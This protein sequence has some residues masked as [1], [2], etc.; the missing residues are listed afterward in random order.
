[1]KTTRVFPKTNP[2]KHAQTQNLHPVLTLKNHMMGAFVAFFLLILPPSVWADTYTFTGTGNWTDAARWSPSA[3]PANLSGKHQVVVSGNCAFPNNTVQTFSNGVFVLFDCAAQFTQE[4]GSFLVNDNCIVVN[5]GILTLKSGIFNTF[6]VDLRNLNTLNLQGTG[7]L[8]LD[9]LNATL[10]EGIFNWTGGTVSYGGN[11][12]LTID[13]GLT[14]PNNGTLRCANGSIKLNQP[15]VNQGTIAIFNSAT[16][17]INAKLTNNNQISVGNSTN[18]ARLV[19]NNTLENLGTIKTDGGGTLDC[20]GTLEQAGV[21]DNQ[22]IFKLHGGTIVA[23]TTA[24]LGGKSNFQLGHWVIEA[25]VHLIFEMQT[26]PNGFNHNSTFNVAENAI[27]TLNTPTSFESNGFAG[28]NKNNGTLNINSPLTVRNGANNG[29]MN[30]NESVQLVFNFTNDGILNVNKQLTL[31]AVLRGNGTVNVKPNAEFV[32]RSAFTINSGV[33][34]LQGNLVWNT[35]ETEIIFP[36]GT[37]NWLEG[38]KVDLT[39]ND[40]TAKTLFLENSVSFNPNCIFLLGRTP[41]KLRNGG[42]L[43]LNNTLSAPNLTVETGS[44]LTVNAPL[45]ITGNLNNAAATSEITISNTGNISIGTGA[46][47]TNTGILTNNGQISM[48]NQTL[49]NSGI[50]KGAGTI[51]SNFVN[52]AAGTVSVGNSAG[53]H[54]FNR[55]FTTTGKTIMEIGGSTVCTQHDKLS[56]TQTAELGGTLEVQFIN[57]FRPTVGQSFTL[58]TAD[59]VRGTFGTVT[60]PTGITGSVSYTDFDVKVNIATVLPVNLMEFSGQNTEGGNLLNWKTAEEQNSSHFDIERSNNGSFFT[61]IKDLKTKGS[62]SAYQFLDTNPNAG[63]NYYRLKINDLDGKNSFSKII[64]LENTRPSLAKIYPSLTSGI[65]TIE[66]AR[67]FEIVNVSG[68]VVLSK[69]QGS[70]NF[71]SF[72]NLSLSHLPNGI[73]VVK[74]MDTEGGVF[75]QKIVKQ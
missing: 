38:G 32:I 23:K 58:L 63:L 62:N 51:A 61:K 21:F 46:T 25:G 74:G 8:S 68:Q 52:A 73:Y 42:N 3:P 70:G 65:L 4:G 37:F 18:T 54:L 28:S 47:L 24:T 43:T 64:V 40:F 20:N 7:I 6:N 1:M 13:K 5:V 14:I 53:C 17:E 67:S 33:M 45:S 57:G 56:V 27:F 44:K 50:Y 71:Q 10:P 11:G 15:V 35:F 49:T 30:V 19:V 36:R 60:F 31:N 59:F 22:G 48:P 75:S 34:N 12:S 72:P 41:L 55:N 39:A 2:L 66:N 26:N 9:N 29:T 69:T 16:I